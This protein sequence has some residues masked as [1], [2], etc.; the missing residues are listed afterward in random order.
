MKTPDRLVGLLNEIQPKRIAIIKPSALGDVVQTLPLVGVLKKKYPQAEIDWVIRSEL[1]NLLAA[2]PRLAEIIPYHRKG[3]WREWMRLLGRLRRRKYDLVF[4]AQGLLRTAV[5]TLATGAP[6]RI[7]LETARECSHL[8]CHGLLPNTT[9]SV[10]AHARYWRLA[11]LLGYEREPRGLNLEIPQSERTSASALLEADSRPLL[12]IHPGAMWITKRWPVASF[13]EIA[14]RA[15]RHFSMR[16]VV[17]GS[18]GEQTDAEVLSQAVRQVDPGAS[19]LNLA[20]KTT[21]MQ[22]AVLLEKADVVLTNDSGPMH[23][24]AGLGTPVVGLFTCTS[25]ERSGPA[26]EQHE[27]VQALVPC[28]ASYRKQCPF[29]G[30]GHLHCM[31]A[32]SIHQVWQAFTRL[33]EKNRVAQRVA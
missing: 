28:A 21:L 11:E 26:G 27:L 12:V 15:I 20:G 19:I 18:K 31:Q 6:L 25:A 14:S 30:S 13:A 5:M 8:A 7:G 23:L 33:I 24:A 3:G 2:E 17:V 29:T 16:V 22:L 9:K 32:L 1:A 4:D 10:P